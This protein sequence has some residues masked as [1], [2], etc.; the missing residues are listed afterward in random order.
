VTTSSPAPVL[1]RPCGSLVGD[2][3][4]AVLARS[5]EGSWRCRQT[6]SSATARFS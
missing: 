6:C 5:R 2:G 3:R 4:V 1:S